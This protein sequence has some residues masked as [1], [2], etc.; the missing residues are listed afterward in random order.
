M[1]AGTVQLRGDSV[2]PRNVKVVAEWNEITTSGRRFGGLEARTDHRG[3]FRLCGVPVGTDVT[4]LSQTDSSSAAPVTVRIPISER[5]ASAELVLDRELSRGATLSGVV[6][7]DVNG[8]P[9]ADVEVAI[10]ELQKNVF[11]NERGA[12]RINDI[13]SGTRVVVARKIGYKELTT[14]VA[15]AGTQTVERSMMLS[16]VAVLDTVV[17]AERG[18]IEF[19]ENRKIGLGRFLTRA[20][21]EALNGQPIASRMQAFPSVAIIR[22]RSSQGWILTS[23]PR[24]TKGGLWCP[25]P[26]SQELVDG[27]KCGCYPQVYLDKALMN[28]PTLQMLGGQRTRVTPPFDVNSIPSTMIEAVE[29]YAGPSQTPTNYSTLGSDCGVLVIH[30]R[31]SK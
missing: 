19:E 9:M 13:P 18:L 23:R 27:L 25:E 7:A 16:R 12:F 10:P 11:T 14:S 28:P 5:F 30:T 6:L 21:L 1:V 8:Q 31:R 29:W 26:R 20:D 24:L 2:P 15:F 3:A 22:G 17:V 4:L